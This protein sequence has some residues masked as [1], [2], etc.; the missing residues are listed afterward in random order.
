MNSEPEIREIPAQ[1]A[2]VKRAES[3]AAGLVAAID[4]GFAALFAQLAKL[5]V[6]PSGA[7]YIRYLETR[8]PLQVELG[9]PVTS[10]REPLNGLERGE[11]PAGR[12]AMLRHIGP[13]EEL[14]DACARL[15]SWV[16]QRGEAASGPHWEVY[17]TNPADEPDPSKR[18][19]DIFLPLQ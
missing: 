8:G 4:T 9:V 1:S 12:V 16:E 5:D 3:D 2:A 14:R 13:Y 7:P 18:I 6:Q 11:L 17:V 15:I 19:T 10:G